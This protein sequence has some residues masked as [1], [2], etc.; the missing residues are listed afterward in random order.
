MEY[1]HGHVDLAQ[2]GLGTV[3]LGTVFDIKN[4]T[5]PRAVGSLL[6]L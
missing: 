6:Q 2:L 4:G 5:L 1:T 3:P